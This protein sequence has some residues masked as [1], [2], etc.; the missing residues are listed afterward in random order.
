MRSIIEF[1]AMTLRVT[2][3]LKEG[4]IVCD[5]DKYKAQKVKE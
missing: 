4:K 1:L 2:H 3:E 5:R